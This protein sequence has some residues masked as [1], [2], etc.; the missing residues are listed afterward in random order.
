MRV[1]IDG[2]IGVG[3]TTIVERLA[4]ELGIGVR[5]EPVEEWGEYLE[6]FYENPKRWSLCFNLRA[7]ASLSSPSSATLYERSPISCRNVFTEIGFKNGNM[8]SLEMETFDA[9]YERIAWVPDAV[10][11]L[12]LSPEECMSRIIE[13]GRQSEQ[14][15]SMAYLKQLHESYEN[16]SKSHPRVETIDASRPIDD[17]YSDVKRTVMRLLYPETQLLDSK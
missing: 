7:L 2:S 17:V 1:S 10:I 12:R 11:Y 3:K 15:V 4:G 13:R 6:R 14:I 5:L 16:F 8:N 9:I